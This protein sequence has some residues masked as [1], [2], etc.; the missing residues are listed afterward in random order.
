VLTSGQIGQFCIYGIV[1]IFNTLYTVQDLV[2][3]FG[4]TYPNGDPTQELGS[5]VAFSF[6]YTHSCKGSL[7]ILA[8]SILVNITILSL[9]LNFFNQTY[10]IKKH[11]KFVRETYDN[12]PTCK[13]KIE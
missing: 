11:A 8:T 1:A 5:T 3:N 12:P 7:W 4:T 6:T 2:V 13:D 10:N 9:F